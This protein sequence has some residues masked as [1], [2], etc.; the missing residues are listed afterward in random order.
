MTATE[1]YNGESRQRKPTIRLVPCRVH[2][3]RS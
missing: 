3:G 2:G 1:S